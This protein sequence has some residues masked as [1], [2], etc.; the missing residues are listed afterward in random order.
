MRR[1]AVISSRIHRY[2]LGVHT[3][4][5]N[6]PAGAHAA[7]G[8]LVAETQKGPKAS[9]YTTM[10]AINQR[11]RRTVKQYDVASII[12]GNPSSSF[13]DFSR[14]YVRILGPVSALIPRRNS[15]RD[16]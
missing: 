9:T 6:Q 3:G 2:R 13:R 12:D 5:C 1:T 4:T 15:L 16:M 8:V 10:P 14:S 11:C 7:I